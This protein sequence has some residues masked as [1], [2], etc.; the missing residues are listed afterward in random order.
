MEHPC[1]AGD[2]L[3]LTTTATNAATSITQA[4][5]FVRVADQ[6]HCMTLSADM[7]GCLSQYT[8]YGFLPVVGVADTH[9]VEKIRALDAA[10]QQAS[11][12]AKL[13][14]VDLTIPPIPSAPVT[15]DLLNDL[16]A[17]VSLWITQIRT[18]T[19]LP[20]NSPLVI[21]ASPQ[22]EPNPDA[23]SHELA[24]W[25]Q[26]AVELQHIQEQ[27]QS[28]E[29]Q[30]VL[31]LLREAKR[32]VAILALENN[33]GLE[34]AVSYTQDMNHFL[35]GYPIE[36]IQAA[37]DWG[38]MTTA[39]QAIF[40]HF[41]KI[42][43]S[44]YYSLQRGITLLEGTTVVLRDAL[45]RHLQDKHKNFLFMDYQSYQTKV[46]YP[47]LD[48]LVQFQDRWEEWKEFLLEQGRRR[49]ITGL[50]KMLESMTLYHLP[51]RERS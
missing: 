46:R 6:I 16:Q 43:S 41:N 9:V 15:D 39:V 1:Q 20:Q 34:Q 14:T 26:L 13:P 19:V 12:Q 50:N 18:V 36:N 49:K 32:F 44:R 3:P 29:I 37:T 21:Q 22:E 25:N 51:L 27:L 5:S 35:K 11:K 7:I 8:R 2:S 42:R 24:F 10:L 31:N 33:T 17:A 47:I 30:N 48:V 45:L 40:D 38:Q 28:S 23:V 4:I